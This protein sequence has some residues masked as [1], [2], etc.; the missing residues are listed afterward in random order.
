M[1]SEKAPG[2]IVSRIRVAAA[3]LLLL[4]ASSGTAAAAREIERKPGEREGRVLRY[5]SEK[6]TEEQVIV[7]SLR[8]HERRLYVNEEPFVLT[9]H[10]S[11]VDERGRRLRPGI[12]W[13][14]WLVEL[15][16]R[17]GKWTASPAQAQGEKVLVQMR[18]LQRLRSPGDE[19]W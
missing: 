11:I 18:V 13:V 3:F 14:G 8:A 6:L 16:Y 5:G 2:E 4:A 12:L 17:T 9:Y 15:R 10:T 19:E 7:R 1:H